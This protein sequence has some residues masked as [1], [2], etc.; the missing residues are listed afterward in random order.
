MV[1]WPGSEGLPI[2]Q[3]YH[4]TFFRRTL[5][6]SRRVPNADYKL[7]WFP[8]PAML[9]VTRPLVREPGDQASL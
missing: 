3:S 8:G 1:C 5:G 9:R 7:A 6:T 4:L 2:T